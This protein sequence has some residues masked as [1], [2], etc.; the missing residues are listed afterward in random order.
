MPIRWGDKCYN[1]PLSDQYGKPE[2]N[3]FT[4]REYMEVAKLLKKLDPE[5]NLIYATSESPEIIQEIRDNYREQYKIFFAINFF[6]FFS[7]CI[8]LFS[9]KVFCIK[10]ILNL[11]LMKMM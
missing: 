8:S 6:F 2:V 7:S 3:C 10:M 11:F 4:V 1:N 9:K 5:V